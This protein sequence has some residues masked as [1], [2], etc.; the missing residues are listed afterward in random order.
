MIRAGA[1]GTPQSYTATVPYVPD[2][3][4]KSITV[5]GLS[6]Q[7]RD[8]LLSRLPVREGDIMSADA[9]QKIIQA[10]KDFDEHLTTR[11]QTA[12]TS[13]VSVVIA[14]PGAEPSKPERIKVGSNVQAAMVLS[15]VTPVYPE[16]AKSARVEGVVHLAVILAKDGTVQEIHSLGGPAL[17]IM[18]AMDA[19]K[20]WVY[21]PTLLNGQPVQVETTVDVNFTLSQ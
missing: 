2:A 15:R 13:G 6:D 12:D 17:L 16:L 20:Q 14:A 4:V 3:S 19:V 9:R 21:R 1:T 11:F 8:E 5:L 18:S 10:A 7:A